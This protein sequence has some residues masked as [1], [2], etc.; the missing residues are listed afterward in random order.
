MYERGQESICA[1]RVEGC[2]I[3]KDTLKLLIFKKSYSLS[4]HPTLC[5]KNKQKSKNKKPLQD[6]CMYSWM[7]GLSWEP[8]WLTRSYTSGENWPFVS[9]LPMARDGFIG[10][11]PSHVGT[12]SGLGLHRF[13]LCCC[14]NTLMTNTGVHMK[15]GAHSFTTREYKLMQPLWKSMWRSHKQLKID[16]PHDPALS[17]LGYPEDS[18]SYYRVMCSSIFITA[19]RTIVR[20]WKFLRF[21]SADG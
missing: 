21:S 15:K 19:L 10:Q 2:W 4:I 8:V 11:F 13:C 1:W 14:Q 7:Y 6:Q 3:L 18:K 12:G 9:Q 20:I 5:P 16:L 17:L